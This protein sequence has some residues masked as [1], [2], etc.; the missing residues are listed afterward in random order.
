MVIPVTL[1]DKMTEELT[2]LFTRPNFRVYG[3]SKN[4]I[5]NVLF[6]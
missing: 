4:Y 6:I 1:P 3:C 5:T 2:V